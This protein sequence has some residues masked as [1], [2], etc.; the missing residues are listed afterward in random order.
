MQFY[1]L[2]LW[3]YLPKSVKSS[4]SVYEFKR[5]ISNIY[6]LMYVFMLTMLTLSCTYRQGC[7]CTNFCCG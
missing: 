5:Y 2:E 4:K 1:G 6:A 7:S 3:N